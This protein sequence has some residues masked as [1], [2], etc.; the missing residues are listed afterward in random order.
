M[1]VRIGPQVSESF[2][3]NGRRSE[4]IVPDYVIHSVDARTLLEKLESTNNN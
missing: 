4:I 1:L 2:D 3:A